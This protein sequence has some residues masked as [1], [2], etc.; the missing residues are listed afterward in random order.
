[1]K[2]VKYTIQKKKII[3]RENS[4]QGTI[5]PDVDGLML[6]LKF[7]TKNL[8]PY[9]LWNLWLGISIALY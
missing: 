9:T 4:L 3:N 7:I 8:K 1:M 5:S 6:L 2:A